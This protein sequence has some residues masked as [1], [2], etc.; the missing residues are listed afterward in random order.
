MRHVARL[1]GFRSMLWV[2]MMSGAVPIG[3]ISVTRAE[4]SAFAP[5][6][7]QLL[8]TFADQAVI[9]IENTR[10]FN[11]LQQ[12]TEDLAESLQQQTATADVLKVISRSAFDLQ[13]VLDTL[14][15]SAAG[16]CEADIVVI[17]RRVGEGFPGAS[18]FGMLEEHRRAIMEIDHKPGRGSLGARVLPK[19]RLY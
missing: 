18:S 10:L 13:K 1:T 15:E 14:S 4:P 9:A 3:I 2:P 12:R 19:M 11:E 17:H 16:L 7:V 8:Q 6:H 5:H